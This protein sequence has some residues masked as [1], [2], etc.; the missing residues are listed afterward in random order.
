MYNNH[1]GD[2]VSAVVIDSGHYEEDLCI[3]TK[4]VLIVIFGRCLKEA[5]LFT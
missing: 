4:K 5:L 1:L 2:K 3:T